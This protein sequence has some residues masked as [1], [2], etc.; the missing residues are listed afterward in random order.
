MSIEILPGVAINARSHCILSDGKPRI[1]QRQ[2]YRNAHP[3]S[4]I[5]AAMMLPQPRRKRAG[6]HGTTLLQ[7]RMFVVQTV[8]IDVV[9]LS[10]G[11]LLRPVI[12]RLENAD[13]LRINISF[14]ARMARVA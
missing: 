3:A 9:V 13:N 11:V 5:A 8:R 6:T 14:P 1:R 7:W 10:A 4:L 12:V 2:E